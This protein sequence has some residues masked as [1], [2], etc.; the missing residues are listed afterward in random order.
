[1]S[2][3]VARTDNIGILAA[4]LIGVDDAPPDWTVAPPL[5]DALMEEG[6][7]VMAMALRN[8]IGHSCVQAA[9]MTA[10]M[11]ARQRE[12]VIL[13]MK[14]RLMAVVIPLLFEVNSACS[15]LADMVVK[16]T[17][18]EEVITGSVKLTTL[19]VRVPEH[20]RIGT[21]IQLDDNRAGF[22]VS[23]R[24]PQGFADVMEYEG[25]PEYADGPMQGMTGPPPRMMSAQ[26]RNLGR[27]F[28]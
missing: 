2:T 15:H 9:E 26:A 27:T 16:L 13:H 23:E 20:A 14:H 24:D 3:P 21:R 8:E 7:V 22:M 17:Q 19:R 10:D 11:P 4:R 12:R 1:M 28:P 5:L 6:D 18:T 25:D